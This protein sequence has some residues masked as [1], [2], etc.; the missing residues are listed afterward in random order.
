M[1]QMIKDIVGGMIHLE[2]N[3]VVHRDLAARNLLLEIR[4]SGEHSIKVTS[5]F[6]DLFRFVSLKK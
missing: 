5:F 4:R 6:L 1:F 3:N 2:S